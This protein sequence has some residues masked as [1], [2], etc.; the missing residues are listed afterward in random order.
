ML[1]FHSFFNSYGYHTM[2]L[3]FSAL[4]LKFKSFLV[5]LCISITRYQCKMKSN[6]FYGTCGRSVLSRM[7]AFLQ[8]C[9]LIYIILILLIYDDFQVDISRFFSVHYQRH[10]NISKIEAFLCYQVIFLHNFNSRICGL[11]A[12]KKIKTQCNIIIIIVSAQYLVLRIYLVSQLNSQR[13]YL[14]AFN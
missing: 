14:T 11:L 12:V 3:Y 2:E 1:K 8:L 7:Y 6:K 5:F 9:N 4:S 13:S 10:L